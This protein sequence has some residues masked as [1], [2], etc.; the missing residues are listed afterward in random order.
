[1]E[2]RAPAADL[3]I[4][5]Q[6]A[7]PGSTGNYL[8][9]APVRKALATAASAAVLIGVAAASP[10]SAE[11][12]DNVL[13]VCS[14]TTTVAFTPGAGTIAIL[15]TP[16]A[17]DPT[18][19]VTGSGA[20]VT[21]SLGLTTVTDTRLA[22]SGWSVS[23]STTDFAPAGGGT[24]IPAANAKFFTPAA[25]TAALGTP[26][27]SRNG[28]SAANAISGGSAL[29]S[30]SHSGPSTTTYTPSIVIAVP[31]GSSSVLYSGTVTQSVA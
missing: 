13:N 4:T 18:Q 3:K 12:S 17:V 7:A 21:M 9:E 16:V 5:P 29:V 14:G 19:V 8:S 22:S 28:T 2:G 23:A 20:N 31:S 6:L 11:C 27:F 26:T 25:P 30:A 24:A 1:M 10:A 15:A